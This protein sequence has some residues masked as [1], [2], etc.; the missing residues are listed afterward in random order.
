MGLSRFTRLR[1][2]R[3]AY[4]FPLTLGLLGLALAGQGRLGSVQDVYDGN[5]PLAAEVNTFRHI[6]RVFPSAT[7][8]PGSKPAPLPNATKQLE[9][10]VFQSAGRQLLLTDYIRFNRVS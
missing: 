8:H 10:V 4:A 5:L 2:L 9:D 6:D 1:N 3:A 7:V